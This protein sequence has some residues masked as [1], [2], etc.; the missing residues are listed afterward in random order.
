[1]LYKT[2]GE[3]IFDVIHSAEPKIAIK[4]VTIRLMGRRAI[5]EWAPRTE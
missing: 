5:T 2:W 4:P 1:M 3:R